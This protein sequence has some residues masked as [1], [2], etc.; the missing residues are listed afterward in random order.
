[1]RVAPLQSLMGWPGA[2]CPAGLADVIL[3]PAGSGLVEVP[4]PTRTHGV[5]LRALPGHR[6]A[7]LGLAGSEGRR[8]NLEQAVGGAATAVAREGGDGTAAVQACGKGERVGETKAILGLC[9]QKTGCLPP[10]LCAKIRWALGR[11]VSFP[12]FLGSS[13]QDGRPRSG[14]RRERAKT[15]G[16]VASKLPLL[17][18]TYHILDSMSEIFLR[19]DPDFQPLLG[20]RGVITSQPCPEYFPSSFTHQLTSISPPS[21]G[22]Q[23]CCCHPGPMAA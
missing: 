23:L 12:I 1:M 5:G 19:D 17:G 20:E 2:R 10:R 18:Q 21:C 15:P 6:G 4:A 22:R 9:V 7:G 13:P 14:P 8:R 3:G 16:K 11:L